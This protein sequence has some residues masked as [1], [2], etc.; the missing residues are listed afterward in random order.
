MKITQKVC[1]KLTRLKQ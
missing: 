1:T